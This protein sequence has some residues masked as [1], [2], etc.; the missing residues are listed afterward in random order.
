MND[1]EPLFRAEEA[2]PNN[3]TDAQKSALANGTAFKIKT[4]V[5][6]LSNLMFTI[7]LA[8]VVV[9]GIIPWMVTT[10]PFIT[11]AMA[12]V[13]AGWM[14][15]FRGL[16]VAFAQFKTYHKVLI[17]LDNACI[18]AMQQE[19]LEADQGLAPFESKGTNPPETCLSKGEDGT[20]QEQ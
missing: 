18:K 13:A 1:K 15:A 3:L 16:D 7:G 14:F 11:S 17:G 12:F 4:E 5:P 10:G 9:M 19:M 6:Y 20:G 8:L 2:D